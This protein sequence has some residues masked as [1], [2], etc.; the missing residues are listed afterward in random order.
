MRVMCECVCARVCVL[1]VSVCVRAC[2][3]FCGVCAR[4]PVCELFVSIYKIDICSRTQLSIIYIY[5]CICE[6][7]TLLETHTQLVFAISSLV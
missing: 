1:C 6:R 3:Y 7:P 2:M 4:T 5:I